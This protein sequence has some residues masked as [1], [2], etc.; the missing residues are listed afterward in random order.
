V[1]D[2]TAVLGGWTARVVDGRLE[3]DGSGGTSDFWR[4]VAVAG[5]THLDET[6]E[7]PS[8]AGVSVPDVPSPVPHG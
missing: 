5:W 4:V 6:G 2:G 8:V 3:V 1:S 7:A